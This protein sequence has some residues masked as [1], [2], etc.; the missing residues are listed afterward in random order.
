[1]SF[2]NLIDSFYKHFNEQETS[3]YNP[4]DPHFAPSYL[5]NCGRQ[6][7]YKKTNTKPSDPISDTSLFKMHFGKI[8]HQGLQDIL[9]KMPGYKIVEMEKENDI[10]YQGLKFKYFIDCIIEWGEDV[11]E[12]MNVF[13]KTE[14]Y[15]IEIKTIFGRA[16]DFIKKEPKE[17]HMLQTLS[18]MGFKKIKKAI[19]LYIDRGS[20]YQVQHNIESN[21]DLTLNGKE[22]NHY[23]KI[24]ADKIH[25]LSWV[26]AAILAEQLYA[27]Q[28]NIVI[29]KI[30]G[31][32]VFDFQ[33]DSVKYKSDWQCTYCQYKTECWQEVIGGMAKKGRNFYIGGKYE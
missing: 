29:K 2:P 7:Y 17:D 20:G 11:T 28:Y 4:K 5:A 19:I 16:V 22:I 21:G 15:I 6:T 3:E 12:G 26:K 10:E 13:G 30:N 9:V 24:W 23:R 27:R 25:E 8:Q 14:Q 32:L 33:K 1:M 18:Y 31:S